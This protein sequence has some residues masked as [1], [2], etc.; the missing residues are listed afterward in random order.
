M[1]FFSFVLND[2][3]Q[4]IIEIPKNNKHNE[5]IQIFKKIKLNKRYYSK[6]IHLWKFLNKKKN[7]HF[8][9]EI[10]FEKRNKSKRIGNKILF[11]IPPNIGLGDSIE[12]GL[13]IKEL[14][15]EKSF[16]DYGI[17][18]AGRFYFIYKKYFQFKNIYKEYIDINNFNFYDT[19]FHFTL[20]INELKKNKYERADIEK[21]IL[22][23]FNLQLKRKNKIKKN[24]INNVVIF[25]ISNSP[26]RTMPIQILKKLID[27]FLIDYNVKVIFYKQSEISNYIEKHID[28]SKVDK[29]YPKDIK[30]LVTE[31]KKIDFGIFM[32]SGPLHLAKIFNKRGVLIETSVN[33]SLL[34]N[35]FNSIAVYKNN[36]ISNYCKKSCGLTNIFNYDNNFGCFDSLK[37]N[38]TDIL[39]LDNLKSLQRG[40]IKKSYINFVDNPVN[41]LKNLNIKDLINFIKLQ[42][43]K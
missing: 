34:L 2:Y 20:E 11:F 17:A 40:N 16:L 26:I 9:S 32:D 3:P 33:S 12:Y 37:V 8:V 6:N 18:F 30:D 38:K 22:H 43:E 1:P 28:S 25:P 24:K 21:S 7:S 39:N 29:I 31:V 35:Q 23:F 13:A 41:C 10:N 19:H 5:L 15:K 4:K 14:V 36:Y 27:Y 42:I